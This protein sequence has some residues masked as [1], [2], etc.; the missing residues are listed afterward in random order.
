MDRNVIQVRGAHATVVWGYHVAMTVTGWSFTGSG[1]GGTVTATVAN[2]NAFRMSQIPLMVEMRLDKT[3]VVWPVRS[4]YED[5]STV[6]IEV[7]PKET[8]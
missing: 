3:T 2:R 5:G 1:T 7:G 6:T 8:R 4:V